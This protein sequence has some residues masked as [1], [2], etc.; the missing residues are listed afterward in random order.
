VF[1]QAT[2]CVLG[3]AVISPRGSFRMQST[4]T[5]NSIDMFQWFDGKI[6]T[7]FKFLVQPTHGKKCL[8]LVLVD[9]LPM[10]PTRPEPATHS[11]FGQRIL[12]RIPEV[13]NTAASLVY[14]HHEPCPLKHQR[15]AWPS[16]QTRAVPV[17]QTQPEQQGVAR[18]VGRRARPQA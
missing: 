5:K 3:Y 4:T 16:A 8:L 7:S 10:F 17:Y 11:P 15:A 9:I 2:E 6:Y 1:N 12:T 14:N 18:H 13:W